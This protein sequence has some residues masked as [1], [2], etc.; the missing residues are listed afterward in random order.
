[1][2]MNT[3]RACNHI[4]FAQMREDCVKPVGHFGLSVV[5]FGGRWWVSDVKWPIGRNALTTTNHHHP[6]VVAFPRKFQTLSAAMREYQQQ[7][8]QQLAGDGAGGG[9][10][11]GAEDRGRA[12]PETDAAQLTDVKRQLAKYKKYA[13]ELKKTKENLLNTIQVGTATVIFHLL[14]VNVRYLA[15]WRQIRQ[16]VI[17]QNPSLNSTRDYPICKTDWARIRQWS[18]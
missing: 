16:F 10:G 12:Q 14:L 5:G 1:M 7:Q 11:G 13:K 8:Q 17:E 9:G 18:S 3:S 4:H 2:D 6:S 15:I